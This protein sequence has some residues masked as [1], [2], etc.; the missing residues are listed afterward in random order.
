MLEVTTIHGCVATSRINVIVENELNFFI[1]NIFS[2]NNDGINDR[3]TM[4]KNLIPITFNQYAI[5]DRYGN[6]VFQTT[7][8]HFNEPN[9]GWDGNVQG[10]PVESGVYILIIDYVDWEGNRQIFKK[11]ITVV[12]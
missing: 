7:S 2:P 12:R 11:D 4:F 5:Y 3:L 8:Q 6:K 1:P 9:E 10:R